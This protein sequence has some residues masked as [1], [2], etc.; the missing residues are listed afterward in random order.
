MFGQHLPAPGDARGVDAFVQV[1]PEGQGEF[2]LP[3]VELDDP[4]DWPGP[5]KRGIEEGACHAGRLRLLADAIEPL[6]KWYLR[7]G[8]RN[9]AGKPRRQQNQQPKGSIH[10]QTA[11]FFIAGFTCPR[12]IRA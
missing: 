3:P 1:I 11:V 5:G 4:F 12:L 8:R 2:R 9:G 7:L 6:R 10:G